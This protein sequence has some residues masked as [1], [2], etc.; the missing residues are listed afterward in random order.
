M[1]GQIQSANCISAI[2]LMPFNAAPSA[3]PAIEDSASGVSIILSYPNSSINPSVDKKTPPLRPISSPNITML[4]SRFSSSYIANL[5]DSSNVI[6][7][8]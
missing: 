5:I 8:I 2:A 7:A 1:A 4:E 3:T 6:I